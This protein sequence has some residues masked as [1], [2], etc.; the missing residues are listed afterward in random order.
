MNCSAHRLAWFGRTI[1]VAAQVQVVRVRF[2][3]RLFLRVLRAIESWACAAGHPSRNSV[4]VSGFKMSG[5]VGV[6]LVF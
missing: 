5:R 6:A 3:P 1:C 2:V 4:M